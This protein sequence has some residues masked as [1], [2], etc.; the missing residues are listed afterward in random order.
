MMLLRIL[1]LVH[2]ADVALTVRQGRTTVHGTLPQA[3]R[4]DIEQTFRLH[5]VRSGSVLLIRDSARWKVV[6]Y[7]GAKAIHQAI[8]NVVNL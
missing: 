2:A 1:R 5:Q 7:G 6:T 4:D 3:L 8:T